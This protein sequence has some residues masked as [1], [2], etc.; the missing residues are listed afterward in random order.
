VLVQEWHLKAARHRVQEL[1]GEF[2]AAHPDMVKARGLTADNLMHA[3]TVVRRQGSVCTFV[4]VGVGVFRG[5]GWTRRV[6]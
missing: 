1:W 2:A 5:V 4:V 6:A 3:I